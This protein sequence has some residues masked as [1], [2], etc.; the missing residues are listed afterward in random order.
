MSESPGSGKTSSHPSRYLAFSLGGERYAIPLL[1]VK[2]V[3]AL[4]EITP[5]PFSAPHFMGIMNLRGQVISVV[6]LRL[7]LGIK[8]HATG[9]T[10]VVI[11]DLGSFCLGVVV[12]SIDSVVA[13]T[14]GEISEKPDFPATRN[15]DL[16][17]SVFRKDKRLIL[18]LDIERALTQDERRQATESAKGA[19]A[20]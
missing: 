9:E 2:E 20:A 6:D 5:V 14:A 8:A 17:V 18:L 10:A 3:I 16:I 13:P 15:S 12:D 4:P 19:K 7:K 1:S 11:C